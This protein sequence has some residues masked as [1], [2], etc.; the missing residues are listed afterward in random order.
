MADSRR[1][2][3]LDEVP[4]AER[5]DDETFEV[6]GKQQMVRSVSYDQEKIPQRMEAD[7]LKFAHLL[8]LRG[9][10]REYDKDAL[11][12]YQKKFARYAKKG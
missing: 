3:K 10:N 11:A 9:Y 8:L 7:F 4:E 1:H 5:I 12:A 2:V 6:G